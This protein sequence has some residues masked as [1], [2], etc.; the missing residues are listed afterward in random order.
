VCRLPIRRVLKLF[1]TGVTQFM[2]LFALQKAMLAK[3]L[4]ELLDV[5]PSDHLA[6]A[7]ASERRLKLHFRTL[8]IQEREGR[9]PARRN[10][11][12]SLRIP[13]GITQN[14]TR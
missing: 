13:K 4:Y 11:K 6:S 8:S 12:D 10:Q 3:C 7:R 1:M 2:K 14:Q 5:F 9:N